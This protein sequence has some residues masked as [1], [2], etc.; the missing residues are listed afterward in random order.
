MI[1]VILTILILPSACQL[2]DQVTIHVTGTIA[3]GVRFIANSG[4]Y[5]DIQTA[6]NL[7]AAAG[8]GEVQIPAGTFNF[9]PVGH[10]N[11][12]TD[13][14][15]IVMVPAGVSIFGAPTQR[16]ADGSVISWGTVLVCPWPAP[17]SA[18]DGG[19]PSWFFFEGNGNPTKPSRFSD[20]ELRGYRALDPT[21]DGLNQCGSM[22]VIFDEVMN[23]RVDH[24]YFNNVVN[25]GVWAGWFAPNDGG[26]YAMH[27]C[28]VIDHCSFINTGGSPCDEDGGEA[29][30]TNE[31][32]ILIGRFHN[33][34]WESNSFNVFGQYN[35]YTTII[36]NCKFSK[37]RHSICNEEGGSVIVRFCQFDHDFGFHTIDN[38]GIYNLVPGRSI[39]VYNCSFTNCLGGYGDVAIM[40]R[41][42]SGLFY[43]NTADSTYT[44][45]VELSH[46]ALSFQ[47]S[48]NFTPNY[49][50]S[51]IG[52]CHDIFVWSNTFAS[53]G[54]MT[55]L[56]QD[57]SRTK[58]N[59]DSFTRAPNATQG[60]YTPYPYPAPQTLGS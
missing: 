7:A 41:A 54:T 38:H 46:D 15:G 2:L 27:C 16:N 39:L 33:A 35:S 47:Q 22:G 28:G 26:N 12:L 55:A 30:A 36:E 25:G 37:W 53:P 52:I 21:A 13:E 42:G 17:G 3:S 4:S 57:G 9:V 19:G 1:A 44:T 8:G 40:M 56:A 34:Q 14:Y 5:A 11:D 48:R 6:V 24:C 18:L 59:V 51:Y 60:T 58:L 23:Y 49:N 10:W 50:A 43:N 31:Y 32:G 20:I 29:G 45:F